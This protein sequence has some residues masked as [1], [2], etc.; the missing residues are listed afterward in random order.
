MRIVLS[1]EAPASDGVEPTSVNGIE[2]IVALTRGKRRF[3]DS[4]VVEQRLKS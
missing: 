1:D 3:C 2:S 4:A